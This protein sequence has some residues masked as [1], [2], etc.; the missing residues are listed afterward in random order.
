MGCPGEDTPTK[1]PPGR[2]LLHDLSNGVIS[3]FNDVNSAIRVD[4][5]AVNTDLGHA[6]STGFTL[7]ERS[8]SK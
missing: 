4:R 1:Q 2:W 3:E 5:N 7:L 6:F 8:T